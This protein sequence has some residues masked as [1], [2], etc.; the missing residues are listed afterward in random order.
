MRIKIPQLKYARPVLPP[1]EMGSV[2]VPLVNRIYMP[3]HFQNLLDECSSMI[4]PI[5]G[6]SDSFYHSLLFTLYPGY[7]ASTWLDKVR[8]V[9]K[10]KQELDAPAHFMPHVLPGFMDHL[11]NLFN[12]NIIVV[13]KIKI[14]KHICVL[15]AVSIFLHFDELAVYQPILIN[16]TYTVFNFS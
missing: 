15:D 14:T 7:T 13:D 2:I 11:A 6:Y 8:L 16:G 5:A 3:E 4:T 10:F 1:H 9:Q 12:V